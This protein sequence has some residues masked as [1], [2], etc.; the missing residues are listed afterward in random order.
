MLT[1]CDFK[2]E[3]GAS[4][5]IAPE[6]RDILP[7]KMIRALVANLER[8]FQLF[9]YSSVIGY[10]SADEMDDVLGIVELHCGFFKRLMGKQELCVF[11]KLHPSLYDD[12]YVQLSEEEMEAFRENLDEGDDFTKA[13]YTVSI[14]PYFFVAVTQDDSRKLIEILNHLKLKDFSQV[15]DAVANLCEASVSIFDEIELL[16]EYSS[17]EIPEFMSEGLDEW[18]KPPEHVESLDI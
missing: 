3:N 5:I 12:E 9:E 7:G 1:K 6:N 17:D 10:R 16:T 11:Q 4:L 8:R 14:P 13:D 15:R 2:M 18:L